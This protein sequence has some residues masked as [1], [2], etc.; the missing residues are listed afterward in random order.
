[1]RLPKVLAFTR[2]VYVWLLYLSLYLYS[3][4]IKS[5]CGFVFISFISTQLIKA[6]PCPPDVQSRD[7]SSSPRKIL[8][9]MVGQS[10]TLKRR[11]T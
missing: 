7:L 5:L 3:H 1:M 2:S 6:F 10:P 9:Y 11:N 4:L 8:K